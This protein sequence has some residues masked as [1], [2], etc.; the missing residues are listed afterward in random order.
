[1]SYKILVDS[2][3]AKDLE[4]LPKRIVGRIDQ[5]I[6]TLADQPRPPGSKLL[7]GKLKNGWRVRIGDYRVL[8][9]IDDELQEVAIFHI[10]HRRDVYR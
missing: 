4:G 8:Y 5:A 3:A 9:R 2:R 10:G 7:R 6:A 1:M